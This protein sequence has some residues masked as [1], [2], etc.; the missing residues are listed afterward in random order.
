MKVKPLDRNT[1][2]NVYMQGK[3]THVVPMLN[4]MGPKCANSL[5]KFTNDVIIPDV[6]V[7]NGADEFTGRHMELVKIVIVCI[8]A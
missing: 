5:I 7:T 3:F 1:C 6:L 4:K 2:A 8:F